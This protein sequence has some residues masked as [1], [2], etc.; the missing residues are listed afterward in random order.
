MVVYDADTFEQLKHFGQTSGHSF[1]SMR[2]IKLRNGKLLWGDLGDNYPRGV[3]I[4]EID[5]DALTK[6]DKVVFTAK[7]N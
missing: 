3:H 4:H 7:V 2:A 5:S 6:Q 1:D